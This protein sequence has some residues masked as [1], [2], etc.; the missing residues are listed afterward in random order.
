V[1]YAVVRWPRRWF[2]VRRLVWLV[3]IGICGFVIWGAGPHLG[4]GV[5]GGTL[6]LIALLA[7]GFYV[8]RRRRRAPPADY[9]TQAVE[10]ADYLTQAAPRGRMPRGRRNGP[11]SRPGKVAMLALGIAIA[12]WACDRF[13]ALLADVR[14]HTGW[15][16]YLALAAGIVLAVAP[17]WILSRGTA[18]ARA[19][20]D[21]R[22]ARWAPWLLLGYMIV[23]VGVKYYLSL[24]YAAPPSGATRAPP[25]PLLVFEMTV[26]AAETLLFAAITLLLL[27]VAAEI[28]A[29]GPVG[30]WLRARF[31]QKSPLPRHAQGFANTPDRDA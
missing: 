11:Q 23:M 17:P 12:G 22:P 29:P 19:D 3:C 25:S 5:V 8:A 1:L 28:I 9:L 21:R 20:R 30:G 24:L 6:A 7:R 31:N 10:S 27:A 15:Y 14:P 2:T 16:W 26:L 18:R 4:P 13:A